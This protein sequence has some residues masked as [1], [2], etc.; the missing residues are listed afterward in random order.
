MRF[1]NLLF[2]LLIMPLA[3]CA[4]LSEFVYKVDIPQGN[5]IDEQQVEKLRLGM[6]KEQVRFVLGTPMVKNSFR[7]TTW[8]YVYRLKTGKGVEYNK[9]LIANFDAEDKLI[10]VEG[11]YELGEDFE[12]PI[13]S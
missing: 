7:D 1:R 9:R 12:T 13:D 5:Y 3:G 6:T 8:Y 4:W 10:A 2:A 11:D